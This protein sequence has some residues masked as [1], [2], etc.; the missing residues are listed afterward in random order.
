MKKTLLLAVV[1]LLVPYMMSASRSQQAAGGIQVDDAKLGKGIKALQIVNESTEFALKERVYLWVKTSG[2]GSR[3][4][5]VT[6]KNGDNVYK[7]NM[8]IGGS[9]WRAWG[10]KNANIP[11]QWTVTIADPQ[12]KVLKELTFKVGS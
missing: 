9:P 10:Y 1:L 7:K 5:V 8:P 3:H 11:G 4:L 2:H 12:G 6:W